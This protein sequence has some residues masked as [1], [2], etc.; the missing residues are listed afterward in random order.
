[1]K[2]IIYRFL[3]NLELCISSSGK[4]GVVGAQWDALIV[5]AAEECKK[6]E[7]ALKA[8]AVENEPNPAKINWRC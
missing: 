8:V 3:C 1:M 6:M 5:V 2:V 4:Q 7:A